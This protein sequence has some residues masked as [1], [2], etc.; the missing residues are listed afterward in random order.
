MLSACLP[1][2]DCA[3][4][5]ND[6]SERTHKQILALFDKAIKRAEKAQK[7]TK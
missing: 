6:H 7:E 2:G 1:P 4:E 3:S 5:Y